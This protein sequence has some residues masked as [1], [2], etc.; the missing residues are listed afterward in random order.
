MA[1]STPVKSTG[2]RLLHGRAR[3]VENALKSG[4]R[5]GAGGYDPIGHKGARLTTQISLAGRYLV[6][7]PGG[8]SA[9]ISRKLLAP[10]RKR[11]KDILGRVVPGDGG[12]I[13]RTAAENVPEEAIATDVNRLHSRWG[14][15]RGTR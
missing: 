12:A 3:K 8:R 1:C 13:I 4:D 10:E 9:G 15:H 2:A 11:L 6:Y 7:V 5:A 14:G